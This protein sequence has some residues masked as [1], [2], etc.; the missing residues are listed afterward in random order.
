MPFL[1]LRLTLS[2]YFCLSICQH[3]SWLM[4]M[5]PYS[6]GVFSKDKAEA[7]SVL[8]PVSANPATVTTAAMSETPML[9]SIPS[10]ILK[11]KT[12]Q[13][14]FFD[15]IFATSSQLSKESL[16]LFLDALLR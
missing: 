15:K 13:A 2:R 3:L 14:D 5:K 4:A 7:D 1:P 10:S 8:S 9:V 12:L 16:A 11:M 6:N